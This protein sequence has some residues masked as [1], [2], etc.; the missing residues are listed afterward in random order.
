MDSDKSMAFAHP[1]IR[2][3]A[4]AIG[5]GADQAGG[6]YDHQNQREYQQ[7]YQNCADHTGCGDSHSNQDHRE[8]DRSQY[9][10]QRRVQGCAGAIPWLRIPVQRCR[11]QQPQQIHDTDPKG[12]SQ[13]NSRDCDQSGDLQECGD[14]TDDGTGNNRSHCAITFAVT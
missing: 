1:Y 2:L 13:K 14:D 4:V 3:L 7:P 8:K 12:N 5:Q 11:D 9:A 6:R 10:D